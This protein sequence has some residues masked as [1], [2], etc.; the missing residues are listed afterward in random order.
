MGAEIEQ[1][2]PEA[3]ITLIP[4]GRGDLIVKRGDELI[5]DKKAMGNMWPETDEL[6]ATLQG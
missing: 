5:W 3:S 6:I 4:G 1:A 2:I